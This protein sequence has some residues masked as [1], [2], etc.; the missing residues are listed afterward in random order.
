MHLTWEK[1]AYTLERN[2]ATRLLQDNT[3][4]T[5]EDEGDTGKGCG[6][7][8]S[9]LEYADDKSAR[10]WCPN[11]VANSLTTLR[12]IGKASDRKTTSHK[13]CDHRYFLGS[14]RNVDATLLSEC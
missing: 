3:T 5:R 12:S 13:Q 1:D 10:S 6:S 11:V 7:D 14:P 8:V 2:K 9:V 4:R